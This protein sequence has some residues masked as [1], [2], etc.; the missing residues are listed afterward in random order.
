VRRTGR[1]CR[2]TVSGVELLPPPGGWSEIDT[3]GRPA[4][5][6]DGE[7]LVPYR[8]CAKKVEREPAPLRTRAPKA[9]RKRRSQRSTAEISA[10][11][12][13][14][15][16]DSHPA[17]TT[18]GVMTNQIPRRRLP[19]AV[20][21]LLATLMLLAAPAAFADGEDDA[22]FDADGTRYISLNDA[23]TI[24]GAPITRQLPGGDLIVAIPLARGA[25]DVVGVMQLSPEGELRGLDG[26]GWVDVEVPEY[27][28]GGTLLDV[29]P[30]TAGGVALLTT[31]L[32]APPENPT[33]TDPPVP[34]RTLIDETGGTVDQTVLS[35]I[36]SCEPRPR[37]VD[38]RLTP[39]ASAYVVW[40]GC[41]EPARI[42]RYEDQTPAILSELPGDEHVVSGM[43]LGPDGDVFVAAEATQSVGQ[44]GQ[45]AGPATRIHRL[46]WFLAPAGYA[47][48]AT[49]PGNLVDLAVDGEGRAVVWTEPAQAQGAGA[50]R[51]A[52][53]AGWQIFRLTAGGAPDP[54]WDGDGHTLLADETLA[55]AVAGCPCR[56]AVQA[57]GKVIAFGRAQLPVRGAPNGSFAIVRTTVDG[58]IDETWDGDGIKDFSQA[59]YPPSIV[60]VGPLAFQA[61]GKLLVP[62]QTLAGA[63]GARIPG[64]P[65]GLALG[66][67]R[68]GFTPPPPPPPPPPTS[69]APQPSGPAVPAAP[70]ALPVPGGAPVVV[71]AES[72][73]SQRRCRSRR[74]FTIRL[75]TGR[76]RSERSPI[77]SAVVRV[78][79]K[80]VPVT[81]R[82]RRTARVNLRNLPKG[83]FTVSIRL[84]LADGGIVR[85]TR[86]YRTCAK[87]VERELAPLRTRAPK[88][89]R[90]R[91]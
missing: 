54:A 31:S 17:T 86:R 80:R 71:S 63:P 45:P 32:E 64:A 7:L 5:Q 2:G 84:R 76:P 6:S 78:N 42:A 21:A 43:A 26:D 30:L 40:E 50:A 70:P 66:L 27:G 46:T 34:V 44:R 56:L 10:T 15:G 87:K 51:G 4:L 33:P 18:D 52:A 25:A 19:G 68:L 39:S 20:G 60:R 58:A 69:P 65:I 23:G 72:V 83:R 1:G 36:D 77:V 47:D 8:T 35:N 73:Q 67:T 38:G 49:L 9:E 11:T 3:V 12:R 22:S 62:F 48:E 81:R 85:E 75:R 82:A 91:R 53:A 74:S 57:D 29:M 79:G 13:D 28:Q 90:K 14:S 55:D 41:A 16:T 24:V 89:E 37:P 61:D 59:P 88:A